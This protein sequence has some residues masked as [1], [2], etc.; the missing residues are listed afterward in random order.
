MTPSPTPEHPHIDKDLIAWLE[1]Y[2][3]YG[4]AVE[5]SARSDAT[6]PKP[7]TPQEGQLHSRA[8]LDPPTVDRQPQGATSAAS[9]NSAST[10]ATS[11]GSQKE[12]NRRTR[13]IPAR[14]RRRSSRSR[15][16]ES[17]HQAYDA[18][19]FRTPF[20]G[21]GQSYRISH[22]F[23]ARLW[24]TKRTAFF[25]RASAEFYSYNEETGCFDRLRLDEVCG[26]IR[27]D[28]IEK[29]LEHK[30]VDIAARVNISLCRSIADLI[31][32][33]ALLCRNDFFASI[34]PAIQ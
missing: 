13:K 5:Q 33:D 29:G 23:F 32:T 24:G 3:P 22:P 30:R 17:D 20:F 8:G 21:E 6:S 7:E 19:A 2:D 1:N 10:E 34:R 26:M 28:V 25:D 31:K 11:S 14:G 4:V 15:P 9:Q 12:E 18:I 16:E 27:D